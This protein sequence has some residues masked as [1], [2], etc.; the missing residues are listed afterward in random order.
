MNFRRSRSVGCRC[1]SRCPR[2]LNCAGDRAIGIVFPSAFSCLSIVGSSRFLAPSS[3]VVT[4]SSACAA[5]TVDMVVF[6][7]STAV[8]TIDVSYMGW[9][10]SIEVVAAVLQARQWTRR[11]VPRFLLSLF[12]RLCLGGCVEVWG[13]GVVDWMLL[14]ERFHEGNCGFRHLVVDGS[15]SAVG[16]LRAAVDNRSSIPAG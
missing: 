1:S 15:L 16:R 12:L 8:V 13:Y 11:R 14:T 6:P 4:K 7:V 5:W 9:I 10:N 2:L 3:V